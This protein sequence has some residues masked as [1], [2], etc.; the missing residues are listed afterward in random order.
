MTMADTNSA[1]RGLFT[2]SPQSATQDEKCDL[3]EQTSWGKHFTFDQVRQM[4]NYLDWY[5]VRPGTVI[6]SEGDRESYLVLIVRG[7][8]DVIKSDTEFLP[9]KIYTVGAGKTLGEM[10]LI[11]GEPRSASAIAAEETH[12]LVMSAANFAALN[13]EL[14]GVG[15]AL[16]LR[17]A[18]Q[19]SQYLR[20]TSGRLIDFLDKPA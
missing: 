13:R 7:R 12:M 5:V 17:I 16:V 19:M 20:L 11:D 1:P 18:R 10:N 4:V 3:M 9:K 6:F 15:L 2:Q 14:P 8:V